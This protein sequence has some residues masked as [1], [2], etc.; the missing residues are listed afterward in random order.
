LWRVPP[1]LAT[2][3]DVIEMV[4]VQYVYSMLYAY[5]RVC[6]QYREIWSV[7]KPQLRVRTNTPVEIAVQ[8]YL[9]TFNVR[10]IMNSPK[11]MVQP[12]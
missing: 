11:L 4:E 7:H 2:A 5:V 12:Q 3:F 1:A 6:A 9:H 8:I 10:E